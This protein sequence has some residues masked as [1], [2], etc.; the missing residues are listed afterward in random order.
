MER[1]ERGDISAAYVN[2]R[3]S[4]HNTVCIYIGAVTL[5]SELDEA[6]SFPVRVDGVTGKE[7]RV[8]TLGWL[9]LWENS[10]HEGDKE[11]RLCA[12]QRCGTRRRRKEIS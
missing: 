3:R 1:R 5:N 7:N 8:L 4:R 9:Q 2:K 10:K 11:P 6:S 12:G